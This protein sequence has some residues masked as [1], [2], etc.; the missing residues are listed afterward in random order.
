MLCRITNREG[1]RDFAV[2]PL[3]SQGC[4]IGFGIKHQTV[5][6]AMQRK[7]RWQQILCA[8][9]RVGSFSPDLLPTA[10]GSFEFQPDRNAAGRLATGNIENMCG[11]GT[12]RLTSFSNLGR[13]IFRCSS[14]ALRNSI[15]TSFFSRAFRISSSS[16]EDFPVAQTM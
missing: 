8:T 13:V 2:K 16:S 12:H 9:I 6:A 4:K 11:D 7:T 15:F 5:N 3:D 14:A 1:Y 10:V